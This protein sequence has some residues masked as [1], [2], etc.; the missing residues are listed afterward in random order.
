MI[1]YYVRA[2]WHLPPIYTL[3]I[4]VQIIHN[5]SSSF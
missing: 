4:L 3:E 5:M 1:A 2:I